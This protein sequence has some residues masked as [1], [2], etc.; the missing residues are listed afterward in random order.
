MGGSLAHH[1]TQMP[2]ISSYLDRIAYSG[3]TKPSNETLKQLHRAH[4]FHV[5]FENLDIGIGRP[6]LVDQLRFVRKIIEEK[7]GGFCYEMNG[8]FAWL[9]KE[10][11]FKVTLLSARVG[12]ADGSFSPEFDH[13]TLKVD[14]DEPW[15]ADVGFGDSFLDPLR[16]ETGLEQ[17]QAN[18]T[19]RIVEQG[20][21]LVVQR[22]QSDQAWHAEYAFTLRP[23]RLEDFA[24]M[25]HYH[26]TSPQSHFTQ[27]K[28]CTLAT[29]DGRITLSKDKLIVTSNGNREEREIPTEKEWLEI[30]KAQFGVV[31]PAK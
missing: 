18:G 30:L 17:R 16:I 26:Q 12:R 15:L 8:S 25:C 14:L 3:T 27:N 23:R 6:I 31:L 5:P 10:L 24:G 9:L 2:S 21:D 29:P 28:V 22:L 19:F 4:L 13:L 20:P 7:R 1:F 11:G